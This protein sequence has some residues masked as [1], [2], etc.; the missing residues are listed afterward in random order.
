MTVVIVGGGIV[1]SAAAYYLAEAGEEVVV[2]E[3]STPGAGSTDRAVGGIRAQFGSPANVALSLRAMDVWERFE[4]A[5][6]VDIEYRRHGYLFL[7]ASEDTAGS[8]AD[9]VA[10]QNELGVPS[11]AIEPAAART[12]LPELHAER[13]VG[14]TYSPAD[15]SADPHLALQGFATAA[16]EAGADIRTGVEVTDVRFERAGGSRRVAGV[17]T[18][19]GPV[20]AEY[21]VNAAGP[22]AGRVASMAGI[23]LPLSPRRRQIA[24]VEPETPYPE[25]APLTVD[26]DTGVH[27]APDRGGDVLLGGHFE[28]PDPERD[29]DEAMGSHDL[30][31]VTEALERAADCAG[32]FGPDS[33]VK[34]GWAGLYT[35]TPDHSPV[36]EESRPGFINAV[37]FSG[38]GFMHSPATGQVVTDLVRTGDTD[39]VDLSAFRRERFAEPAAGE[40]HVI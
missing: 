23:D 38:H 35:V 32:Y 22:W 18:A 28:G 4:E 40:S 26:M 30:A 1:G 3:R 25:N 12:Y 14:A 20:D 39:I 16:R 11:E 8:L 13:Y 27:F 10:M 31:W 17:D 24:V 15:G 33:R 6:G 9:S 7:T 2:C 37:G 19:E 5:F 21:V 29:P 34:N 36:I